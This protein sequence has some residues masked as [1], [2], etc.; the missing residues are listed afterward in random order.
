MITNRMMMDSLIIAKNNAPVKSGNL[1][2][3]AIKLIRKKNGF[4]IKYS[5]IDAYYIQWVED[6]SIK[7]KGQHFIL[8]TYKQLAEYFANVE[9]GNKRAYN[10]QGSIARSKI[11]MELY[12]ENPDYRRLVHRESIFQNYQTQGTDKLYKG[13]GE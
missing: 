4:T 5:T 13:R 11:N 8:E 1:S 7:Q 2:Q 3:N 6:G 12:R 10:Q 9:Q